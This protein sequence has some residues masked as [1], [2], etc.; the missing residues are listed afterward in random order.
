MI[1]LELRWHC[2]D[3]PAKGD[4][5]RSDK[6]AEKHKTATKHGTCTESRPCSS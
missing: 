2:L 5:P 4:G 1:T 6:D 3:C